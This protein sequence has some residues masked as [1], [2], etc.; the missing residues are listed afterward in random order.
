[1]TGDIN[2]IVSEEG[3]LLITVPLDQ[4]HGLSGSGKSNIV[5]SSGGFIQIPESGVA[6]GLN[7][8]RPKGKGK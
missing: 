5:A 1:M 4:D 3:F 6:F 2:Y 8:I 7:V